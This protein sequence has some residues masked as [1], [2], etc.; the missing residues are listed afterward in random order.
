[1]ENQIKENQEV[2]MDLMKVACAAW[3]AWNHHP[4]RDCIR[5]YRSCGY[6]VI[7]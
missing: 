1:M 5:T 6:D 3:Q 2:E 4:F 7:Y